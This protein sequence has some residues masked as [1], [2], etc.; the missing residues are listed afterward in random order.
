M[1]TK[2]Q[3]TAETLANEGIL[4]IGAQSWHSGWGHKRIELTFSYKNEDKMFSTITSDMG[5]WDKIQE[6][7]GRE[8]EEALLDLVFFRIEESLIIWCDT[9]D[10]N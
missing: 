2:T 3:T 7:E 1:T 6:L 5:N 4:F 9:I 8:K 10:N